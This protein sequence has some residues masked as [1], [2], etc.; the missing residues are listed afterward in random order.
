MCNTAFA[1]SPKQAS[2]RL[3]CTFS[4]VQSLEGGELTFE[5]TAHWPLSKEDGLIHWGTLTYSSW[6]P[7]PAASSVA[8]T[9][10]LAAC[11]IVWCGCALRSSLGCGKGS[12]S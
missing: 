11:F 5:I 6:A 12:Y 1:R 3:V 10:I 8:S 4:T 7:G 2:G 9:G